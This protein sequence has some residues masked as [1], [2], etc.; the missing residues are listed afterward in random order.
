M[1]MKGIYKRY[2]NPT[3]EALKRVDYELDVITRM[4]YT[5]YYL[6]VWD[7]FTMQRPTVY[8]LVADVV[9]VQEVCVL[10]A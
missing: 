3:K 1:C 6:I 4:G 9:Q 2:E 7:L 5:D 8:L 10:I